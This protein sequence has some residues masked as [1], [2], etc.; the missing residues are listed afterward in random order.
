MDQAEG[1]S[2]D[3][4]QSNVTLNNDH[5]RDGSSSTPSSKR[6]GG[7]LETSAPD[8]SLS[9]LDTGPPIS[10]TL[11]LPHE[12]AFV[13]VICLAQLCTQIG[14]I[15]CLA[16]I[17]VIG[18]HFGLSN[19]GELSWLIAAYS[20]T[21]GTFILVAGRIGDLFGHKR[22]WIIGFAWFSVWSL[23][24]GLSVYSNH[25]LFDFA[26]VFQG[27]GPA[28]VLPNGLAILGRAYRPGIRKAMAFSLFGACAPVGAVIG[29]VVSGLFNLTYWPWSFWSFSIA[30]ACIAL[31]GSF[32]IPTFPA[33]R[34]SSL[35]L[36]Q[37][38]KQLDIKGSLT[39]IT[40]LILFNF[41][42]N[43]AGVVGWQQPYLPVTLVLGILIFLLFL[44]VELRLA[45]YPLIPV[46]AFASDV[47]FVL[48]C[49]S[50][51]WATFGIWVYY[52][53]QF[54]LTL[55]HASPLLA[56]AWNVPV[57]ISGSIA[58]VTTGFVLGRVRPAAVMTI[59]LSAFCMGT[60]LMATCP[61]G[62]TYWAQ[63]FVTTLVTPWGMDMS[64]PAATLLLSNSVSKEHQGIAA[65]L[66]STFVN[67]S[68]SL[69]L[70][71]AGTVEGHVN[72]GGRDVL[73]GFRGAWYLGIG[74]SGLGVGV[75]L[76]FMWRTQTRE[77]R[78]KKGQE[79]KKESA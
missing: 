43:Q 64:F 4:R 53:W 63:E 25:V 65:S 16:I 54:N 44:Y 50:A 47:L 19:P 40:A 24:A 9:K 39:G 21:V 23:V 17:H 1:R 32:V 31:I 41:A 70:G 20:L 58:A 74:I 15:Q 67:Y 10:A 28:I 52:L 55:R 46:E 8:D 72:D 14:L 68:I 7:E 34:T 42:W 5:E 35:P 26:R 69:G 36:H 71:L 12:I 33:T 66:V 77:K 18:D 75:S 79:E 3:Y 37:K 73:A 49:I 30:L 22:M 57:A 45:K 38:V 60:I 2:T 56:A 78:D 62:Q 29:G 11:S 51:G 6:E 13:A 61:V 48:A 76:L 27:M 59:A